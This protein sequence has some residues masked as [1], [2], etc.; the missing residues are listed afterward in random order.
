MVPKW[1]KRFGIVILWLV[2]WQF[3]STAADN[4]IILVGPLEMLAS[5][6]SS[7]GQ[8][9]F[10]LTILSSFMRISLGFLSAFFLGIFLAGLSYRF[11]IVTDFLEPVILLMKSVP[12]AS[13]IILAL[14][15]IGSGNLAVLV[16]FLIVFPVIYIQVLTGLMNTDRKLLEMAD[17]FHIK[18]FKRAYYI[19]QPAVLPYLLSGCQSALG[20]SWK[21]GIAAEV[22]GVPS[23]SIGEQLYMSKIYLDTAGLFAWTF[24]VILVS[25]LSELLFLKLLKKLARQ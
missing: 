14:I 25:G 8:P 17:I 2:I 12:V 11:S 18:G 20:M 16:S 10:W 19:Y 6:F 21:S 4:S 22:I 24:V 5:L 13:F 7:V 15:W 3:A 23:S 9:D 1:M